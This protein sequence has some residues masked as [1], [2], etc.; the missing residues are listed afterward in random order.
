MR[1]HRILDNGTVGVQ[2]KSCTGVPHALVTGSSSGIGAA[3]VGRLAEEGVR[4]S[5][6][7]RDADCVARVAEKLA[8]AG[9]AVATVIGDVRND[10]D[11]EAVVK[12]AQAVHGPIN[13]LI[14]NAGRMPTFFP[15]WETTSNEEWL[16]LYDVNVLGAVRFVRNVLPR[17][18]E[19]GWGRIVHIGSVSADAPPPGTQISYGASKAALLNFSVGLAKTLSGTGITVNC[20]SPGFID[21][22]GL[23]RIFEEGD[24]GGSGLG[25]TW[26]EVR[27]N[28]MSGVR[29]NLVGRMGD[30]AEVADLVAFL[31][32]TKAGYIS[33]ANYRIDGGTMA[34]R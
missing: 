27:N 12:E 22:P 23:V 33:G 21:T 2:V 18:R 6:H 32:S 9:T 29:R 19:S 34:G 13:I 20:V 17:M 24:P 10:D 28:L 11:V 3:I 25:T 30:A 1:L 26:P 15:D 14:N 5:I 7:G 4:V 8:G 31:C 16:D